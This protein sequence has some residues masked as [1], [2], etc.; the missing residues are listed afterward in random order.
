MRLL[1]ISLALALIAFGQTPVPTPTPAPTTTVTISVPLPAGILGF[2]SFN[3]LGNPKYTGGVAAIY[4]VIGSIG[5]YGTTTTDFL[6]KKAIDPT[7]GR[8][9]Y[10]IST[11]VRQGFHKSLIS[12]GAFT[13]LVGADVGPSFSEST[14]AA[15]TGKTTIAVSL[16]T[17][18]TATMIYQVSPLFSFAVPV[19]MLYE[20][21]IGWN[22]VVEAGV[23][24]NL[25][26]LPP[27][28]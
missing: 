20:S 25:Q 6:P 5:I 3:Q 21:G 16:S 2:G 18:A 7:T 22:P 27:K 23:I 1:T 15:I 4:P 26:K 11:S 19:R 9:F 8:S 12:T 17:S 10:A 28:K 14:A 13:F 24:I